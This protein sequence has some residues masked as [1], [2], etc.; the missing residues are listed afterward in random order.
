MAYLINIKHARLQTC[1][2]SFR[3]DK[4]SVYFDFSLGYNLL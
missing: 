2:F 1:I 3:S 4:Y